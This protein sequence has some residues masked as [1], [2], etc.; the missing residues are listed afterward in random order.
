MSIAKGMIL[1]LGYYFILTIFIVS[2]SVG[3]MFETS[4]Q[5]TGV[6]DQTDIINGSMPDVSSDEWD[7]GQTY[8]DLQ[9]FNTIGLNLGL[10]PF[11]N[12]LVSFIFVY[13]P[14]LVFAIFLIFAVRGGS[15]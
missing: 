14:S 15:S 11:G 9:K 5:M 8:W 7:V 12:W 1:I 4:D 10:N 13:I 2:F 3:G 6:I